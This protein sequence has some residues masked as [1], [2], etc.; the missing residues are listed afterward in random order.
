MTLTYSIVL[1]AVAVLAMTIAF[2]IL[3]WAKGGRAGT[4]KSNRTMKT[5]F[6]V[7]GFGAAALSITYF[8]E[9]IGFW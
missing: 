3:P 6:A 9:H 7:G 2:G 1:L 5:V 8:L 4:A